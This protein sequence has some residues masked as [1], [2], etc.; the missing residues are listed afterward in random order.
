MSPIR[1]SVYQGRPDPEKI[2]SRFV[3]IIVIL[4]LLGFVR[5]GIENEW[6]EPIIEFVL[7]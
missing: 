5:A 6:F 1:K 3:L 2:A 7:S 4:I